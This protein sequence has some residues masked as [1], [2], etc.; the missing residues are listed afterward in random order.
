MSSEKKFITNLTK[1]NLVSQAG[2]FSSV[3]K[4]YDDNGKVY[5]GKFPKTFI[6]EDPNHYKRIYSN[7]EIEFFKNCQEHS[8]NIANDIYKRF[9]LALKPEGVYDV[10]IEGLND[11]YLPAFVNELVTKMNIKDLNYFQYVFYEKELNKA[12]K[13]VINEGYSFYSDVFS[14]PNI[15]YS[16]ERGVK[17]NDFDLWGKNGNFNKFICRD[18]KSMNLFHKKAKEFT[19]NLKIQLKI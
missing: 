4:V 16:K 7:C 3:F 19:E 15:F 5:C 12:L 1:E 18:L 8:F 17:F 9:D 6:F 2:S 13:K 14:E 10:K 11:F